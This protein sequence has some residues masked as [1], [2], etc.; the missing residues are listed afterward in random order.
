MVRLHDD[1]DNF[2]SLVT[3][4]GN[5]SGIREDILE[6]DYY[7]VLFLEELSEMQKEG[8]PAYF[9]GGTALY[10]M[11][12]SPNRFSEDIDLSV[13]TRG[14]SN[15]QNKVLL[16]RSTKKFSSLER[17]PS[18][19]FSHRSEMES[20][21]S[22]TPIFP[23]SAPDPLDRFGTMKIEATSFT[24]PEPVSG[25]QVTPLIYDFADD[26]EKHT[27]ESLYGVK[28][29]SVA[30][31]SMERIFVDKL[32][33]AEGYLRR[34]LSGQSKDF[35][36]SKQ[37]YDLSVLSKNESILALL[38]NDSEMERLLKIQTDEEIKRHGGIGGV[39]P[40]DFMLFSSP[41]IYS[42]LYSEYNH[43]QNVYVFDP[44]YNIPFK[45][46]VSSVMDLG[47]KLNSKGVWRD[48]GD[49]SSPPEPRPAEKGGVA[50]Y[51]EAHS[52]IQNRDSETKGKNYPER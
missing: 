37:I 25:V 7:V 21:Y 1:P 40:K 44:R 32:F 49:L 5:R 43:M 15:S 46:A 13:D 11:L 22:Y 27:L 48:F 26:R 33:A 31:I 51:S 2:I 28:P 16:E 3:S 35:E 36:A 52:T 4:V 23:P 30:C 9:K 19:G 17:D 24:T 50:G 39:L 6:K 14:K 42:R 20:H 41:D 34:T 18:K 10:K 12:K 45:D 29:F 38:D 8:L 47:E